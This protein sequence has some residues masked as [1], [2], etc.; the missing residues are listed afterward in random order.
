MHFK[1]SVEQ[2]FNSLSKI[3]NSVWQDL[4]KYWCWS[5]CQVSRNLLSLAQ[6]QIG[7]CTERKKDLAQLSFP[8]SQQSL[9]KI[10][11]SHYRQAAGFHISNKGEWEGMFDLF[12]CTVW[13]VICDSNVSGRREK[14]EERRNAK[15]ESKLESKGRRYEDRRSISYKGYL[16]LLAPWNV[17]PPRISSLVKQR[18]NQCSKDYYEWHYTFQMP[19]VKQ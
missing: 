16:A 13:R 12:Q 10:H 8:V 17:N 7:L 3:Y 18:V 19:A 11:F 14:N 6:G 2:N 9:T 4:K 15:G 5:A 1:D